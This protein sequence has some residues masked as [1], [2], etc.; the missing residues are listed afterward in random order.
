MLDA[1]TTGS[2]CACA[3]QGAVSNLAVSW[4]LCYQ[5][6]RQ[7][8]T[9]QPFGL[10]LVNTSQLELQSGERARRAGVPTRS[11]LNKAG[12]FESFRRTSLSKPLR[13]GTPALR[14]KGCSVPRLQFPCLWIAFCLALL[15]PLRAPAVALFAAASGRGTVS[16][17]PPTNDFSMGQPVTLTATPRNTNWTRF[18]RWSDEDT[19]STRNITIAASNNFFTAVFTNTVALEKL[20]F[21]L[22]Q[23]S[24]GG[25]GVERLGA[26]VSTPD[27][28]FLLGG[29]SDSSTNGSRSSQY[30]G[31]EDY[32]V[33]KL[34]A[35]GN[36]QWDRSFGGDGRDFL[37]AISL[38][39]DGGYILAG[40]SG[41]G[42]SGNK[43]NT[44][45]GGSDFWVVKLDASGNKQWDHSYGGTGVSG[46]SAVQPTRDGGYIIGGYS[47][48]ADLG[49]NKTA[50]NLG[51]HDIWIVKTDADGN[52]Q[53]DR[54]F[55]ASEADGFGSIRQTE[56]GGYFIGGTYRGNNL[57][58][59]FLAIKLDPL[60]QVQW[61]S[62]YFGGDADN[63]LDLGQSAGP[64]ADG[65]YFLGGYARSSQGGDRTAAAHLKADWWLLRLNSVGT[66][67]WDRAFGGTED[68]ELYAVQP[69]SD[70]GFLLGGFSKSS[71][72]GNKLTPG[73]GN[74]DFWVVRM[75]PYGNREWEAA[76]GGDD[77]DQLK[78]L[79]PLVDGG[80]LLA[81]HSFSA[82]NGNKT[83]SKFGLS[84]YWVVRLAEREAPVG[85][86]VVLVNALFTSSNAFTFTETNAALVTLSTT[87]AS[88]AIRYTLDGSTPT[89]GSTLYTGP[90]SIANTVSVS[91]TFILNAMAWNSNLTASATSGVVTVTFV[92][93]PLQLAQ[94]GR[95][96]I[97]VS[98]A[99]PSY[100]LGQQVTLTATPR[101]TNWTRFLRWSD[102]NTNA[103]RTI[104]VGLTNSLTATFTN[105]I[106]LE[107]VDFKQW[108]VGLGGSGYDRLNDVRAT[109]D[110]G[111]ILGGLSDSPANSSK[112]NAWGNNDYWV[113][114][115]DGSG[116]VQWER[117]FGG[118]DLDQLHAV[119]PVRGGG[120]LLV[121]YSFS[122]VTGNKTTPTFGGGD[123]WLIRI[124]D[125][126]NRLWERVYGGTGIEESGA[127]GSAIETSDGGFLITGSS[128]SDGGTGNKTS[129]HRTPGSDFW[130]LKL[131]SG[132][133]K[134]WEE[135]YFDGGTV[136]VGA[137]VHEAADAYFINGNTGVDDYSPWSA[138]V[139]KNNGALISPQRYGGRVV[140]GTS[141]STAD[142]GYWLGGYTY[143]GAP[144]T[145]DFWLT[146]VDGSGNLITNRTFDGT[147]QDFLITLFEFSEGIFWAG[148]HS[149]SPRAGARTAAT[150]GDADCWVVVFDD[151][152]R[153]LGDRSYG[154]S[155]YEYLSKIERATDG[156][157]FLAA[158]SNS[159]T[160]ALGGKTTAPLGDMDFWLLKL[161]V[162]EIPVGTPV[163]RINGQYSPSN[164]F[165][166]QSVTPVAVSITLTSTWNGPI[167]YTLDGSTPDFGSAL[168]DPENP[169]QVVPPATVKAIAYLD[170]SYIASELYVDYSEVVST[171]LDYVP[172]YAL[173]LSTPGGGTVAMT[174]A[175]PT[176]ASNSIV[177]ISATNLPGWTFLGWQGDVTGTNAT[178]T[179]T[180]NS[181]V[182][183]QAIFG[184]PLT[185]SMTGSG[186]IA[187]TPALS[188]YPYG[189]TVRLTA[190]PGASRYLSL[191]DGAL[192][193]SISPR[194]LVMTNANPTVSAAFGTITGTNFGLTV[195]ITGEG[196]ASYTPAT[197][198]LGSNS[199]VTL[200]ATPK[201]GWTFNGWSGG[202][203]SAL[204][205]LALVMNTNKIITAN[206]V[207][208]GT[209][210]DP[211]TV[212]LVHPTNATVAAASSSLLL[213]ARAGDPDGTVTR[214]D[215]FAGGSVVG[216]VTNTLPGTN[217]LSAFWTNAPTGSFTLL[218]VAIDNR[219]LAVTSAP[220]ALL[221]EQA[222]VVAIQSPIPSAVF[223]APA[224]VPLRQRASDA[225]GTVTRVDIFSGTT[226]LTTL[227]N[228]LPGTNFLTF[229]WM[230]VSIGTYTLTAVAW[231]EFGLASTS[232]PVVITV[233]LAPTVTLIDPADGALYTAPATVP[234][235]AEAS[236][237]DGV[238]SRVDF[239]TDGMFLS[240]VHNGLG[241]ITIFNSTWF[242]P[243]P[244]THEVTAVAVDNLGLSRT[245]TAATIT[246]HPA[247]PT[248]FFATNAYAVE[249]GETNFWVT[250]RKEGG[251]AAS[252]GYE[253]LNGTAHYTADGLSD[254][255]RASGTL[256]F[257]VGSSEQS[258]RIL[259]GDDFFAEPT[260]SFFIRLTDP[261]PGAQL[262]S[263]A[264]VTINIL[265]SD[266]G[267]D[268]NS[269][270]QFAPSD[271]LDLANLGAIAM[272]LEGAEG[273]GQWRF[274]W[275]FAW[276]NSGTTASGLEAGDWSVHYSPLAGYLEP[277][278]D[279]VVLVNRGATTPWSR[280]YV[281]SANE[282]GTL[283][284]RL[285]PAAFATNFGWRVAGEDN[286]RAANSAATLPAGD[287]IL[288]FLD[289]WPTYSTPASAWVH[290]V[291]GTET[292][293]ATAYGAG[294]PSPKP[295]VA[296]PVALENF[297]E[298]A[299]G[300]L[301]PIRQPNEYV[302]QFRTSAGFGSGFAVLNHVVLTA[303][304]VIFDD[305]TMETVSEVLWFP[306]R[307][308]GEFE[309][310]PLRARGAFIM[311]G[312]IE[313]R[314]SERTNG[315]SP[316]VS[317]PQSQA[318][319]VA[320]VWFEEPVA[321][322]GF[323]GYL[324]SDNNGTNYLAN[325]AATLV[326][327][328]PVEGPPE[329]IHPNR[330]HEMYSTL[331]FP[332]NFTPVLVG[333][334]RLY[335]TPALLSFPG[336]SGGPV[337]VPV[338]ALPG[339]D[340]SFVTA[341][342]YLGT[343]REER[344]LVRTI[345]TNVLAL[346]NAA[347]TAA[348]LGSNFG[349]GGII[350][351][352]F[353]PG[354]NQAGTV[355]LTVFLQPPAAIARGAGWRFTDGQ[356]FRTNASVLITNQG[357]YNYT[358]HFA[359]NVPGFFSLTNF[360][361]DL[362]GAPNG[363][364][365][366]VTNIYGPKIS[367]GVALS[368]ATAVGAGWRFVGETN[369][370]MSTVT[371]LI[372]RAT[373]N[374]IEFKPLPRFVTPTNV[375]LNLDPIQVP[376]TNQVTG[377]YAPRL[378]FTNVPGS[379]RLEGPAGLN[380]RIEY[381]DD[382]S[383]TQTW[384]LYT[385]L[386]LTSSNQGLIH[387]PAATNRSRFYRA[388]FVP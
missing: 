24:F 267:A 304:H 299:E 337:C 210:N 102:G 124:D 252:V 21:P 323:G 307:H 347:A 264:I 291:P 203:N 50:P 76:F 44:Y 355:R 30:F 377:F 160:N 168:Y 322:H 6:G 223:A 247:V 83:A 163:T 113:V 45:Y 130:V 191:W 365:I 387:F 125:S 118:S 106:V 383:P 237:A 27:G 358:L 208:V 35:D 303:A 167:H 10:T 351:T 22:W 265:A 139:N 158:Y 133:M 1:T 111:C 327:G 182:T 354:T 298:I 183:A 229:S 320:A 104:V 375:F 289:R 88:G 281:A 317:T 189:S 367:L 5:P 285:E 348:Q 254:Y 77:D 272:T 78:A 325:A 109:F 209:F 243:A 295:G 260:E 201:P 286:W 49:G 99:Y 198:R 128:T 67:Q 149:Y 271:H 54:S 195:Q 70:G 368:P 141:I 297:E 251:A 80:C 242:N 332:D 232:A 212:T 100:A 29:Q 262:G 331:H 196:T 374:T 2:R 171:R 388:V 356:P 187:H 376:Q 273:R 137:T 334:T 33:V 386:V 193:G 249:E 20:P 177:T 11:R 74:N 68:D 121:G 236:D 185:T 380:S 361:L 144:D 282:V 7:P 205:P 134:E 85:T 230:N 157:L 84:D 199:V 94:Q 61:S 313:Q 107:G 342:V 222:P 87:F 369:Y 385:N 340:S 12:S 235:S 114:K 350:W 188:L 79:V 103:T 117:T 296:L 245:S 219:G 73:F 255:V 89:L 211:P 309:P 261:S 362:R 266:A 36:L 96:N 164:S 206:F 363:Q 321:R 274:P 19:N 345:D 175:A 52:W 69:M 287:H 122:G 333:D 336:N 59:R 119:V 23:K 221:V 293:W 240:S 120:H 71:A 101:N 384:R 269:L 382:L 207:P 93:R 18:L 341:G 66:L 142:S 170:D 16:V 277:P 225:D 378:A 241:T 329:R 294:P 166:F 248:F 90:F 38:T 308:D 338:R 253:T 318:L 184:T 339:F 192:S 238:V 319:D 148:G 172:L 132:G 92:A 226:L 224:T 360:S 46:A 276:R 186:S 60:G 315:S 326:L 259:I 147:D 34:D 284:V 8:P 41:S 143:F 64:L 47:G 328:Y 364:S 233:A 217:V 234:L 310:L 214:V 379:F 161:G 65:G 373:N 278:A 15:L 55:G 302:G 279:P 131:D 32:W 250:I 140:V 108:D 48:D 311:P 200:T 127:A 81:G 62:Q 353:T 129:S 17:A 357:K 314:R 105:F 174:P 215:F 216:S 82:V 154:G 220:V 257:P 181:N 371:N 335:A 42:V 180:M 56:D 366:Y 346:I 239:Y 290:V 91:R 228:A 263:P 178:V 116:N 153:L 146:R 190:L 173:N 136:G 381:K 292:E 53:W 4:R 244:G 316:G 324:V 3:V 162:T 110:G 227:S 126:G 150:F 176:F 213:S 231:D 280:T 75:D 39:P 31:A 359:E 288:E 152:G 305:V 301:D 165:V 115:L 159:G 256:E 270:F 43:T 352:P 218:A 97:T 246:V 123:L 194:D 349:S 312:Y 51:Q 202:S 9:L 25:S 204:N 37:Y 156:G 14:G 72:N 57:A 63:S 283:R 370:R 275:D 112:S 169:P 98:P 135:T 179:V 372:I 306:Q 344:S 155:G 151:Q 95:G 258:V 58:S 268:T 86:P 40:E 343:D 28:G 138:R 26:A 300:R 13:M 197:N 145:R 330:M